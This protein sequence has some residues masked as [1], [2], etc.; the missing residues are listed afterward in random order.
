MALRRFGPLPPGRYEL[1]VEKNGF[2]PNRTSFE[3]TAGETLPLT[4]D[5]TEE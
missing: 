5:L 1:L 4:V 3:I 2:A